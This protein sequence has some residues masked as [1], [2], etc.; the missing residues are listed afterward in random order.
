M[1]LSLSD[2]I[3]RGAF[4]DVF[5]PLPGGKAFKLFR[6]RENTFL[7]GVAPHVF[8]SETAAL[9]IASRHPVLKD[10]VP[11]Y[12]GPC[13]IERVVDMRGRSMNWRYWMSLCYGMERLAKDP[14][15][16]KFGSFFETERWSEM[17]QLEAAFEE[18][19]I[20][21]LG[22]ASVLHWKTGHPVLI[23]FAISD[24]AARYSRD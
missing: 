11:K 13:S 7:A 17:A 5:A 23:D 4:A 19:G 18:A 8:R 20:R 10:Y 14:Q 15:E 16:R 12:Y 24:A 2:R 21:H 1:V 22:D 3:G 9:E 6:R